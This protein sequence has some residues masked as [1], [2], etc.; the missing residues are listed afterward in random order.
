MFV[1]GCDRHS[2]CACSQTLAPTIAA[3][4]G[5]TIEKDYLTMSDG[6][7]LAVTYFK[8]AAQSES[9]R[10]P[11]VLEM[12][13]YRKDDDFYSR[14]YALER[15]FPARGIAIAR[16]DVRGTGSSE[17]RLPDREYSSQELDDAEELVGVLAGLPWSNGHIGMQGVSWG[18]F[19]SIMTAMRRPAQLKAI[20]AA[21]SSDDLYGSDVHGIDG[22][23]HLDIFMFEIEVENIVPRSPDY[24]VDEGYFKDRFEP[25]PWVFNCLRHQRDGAFW[26]DGRSLQS[27][28][29]AINV[30][31]YAI[32]ALLDGYR[33]T[34][35]HMLD[36]LGV[37]VH[38]EIGPWNHSWPHSGS[39]SP[40]YEWRDTAVRWWKNWLADEPGPA[41][42]GKCLSVFMRG[43]VPPDINL[44]E[45]PG[46]FWIEDWPIQRTRILRLRPEG[47][48]SLAREPG[49]S[50]VH[51]LAYVPSAGVA[52]GNWWGETTGD[53]RPADE[54]AL[55]YD[56][57]VLSE[58]VRVMGIAEAVLD[59]A[60]SAPMADW[61]VRLEDVHPGDAGV[62]LVTGG[63][64]N[65]TQRF[66]RTNPTPIV[67]DETFTLRVPLRFT[68]YTF[69]AGHRIRLVVS[70]AQFPMI[71]PT[72]HAMT[73]SLKVGSEG[74]YVE[75]PTVSQGIPAILPNPVQTDEEP[76]DVEY[77]ASDPLTPFE[78]VADDPNGIT[79][80]ES[81]EASSMR[82]GDKM[83]A[84][85]NTV[86]QSVD[87]L[88]PEQ[89]TLR[90]NGWET[91]SFDS[92][93]SLRVEVEVVIE[94]NATV[95]DTK[96]TR[97]VSENGTLL[98]RH[99]W[100]QAISRDFQ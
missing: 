17:G 57:G 89:A 22:G 44:T 65:G 33:D 29:G 75:I 55:V 1:S 8:P 95:F 86:R 92:G 18:G 76:S 67:P 40:N 13:P 83:F 14:D 35:P 49:K 81:H 58:P 28:W 42:G 15:Y 62:S 54:H 100:R 2:P 66:S 5:V 10:F 56:S 37:P 73:T 47:D 91:I 24:A 68:T 74:S 20:L 64:K 94:S 31:V 23:L 36:N 87:N 72:P 85:K 25:E 90:G 34:V 98:R 6:V 71:W 88:H 96:V 61:I 26:Q 51:K 77:P 50:D 59:V 60:S 4:H 9:E 43:S 63:L 79:E 97:A 12:L 41:F 99:A 93:R 7:R 39:P 48:F 53:M 16:V 70:N 27:D 32:G 45:T 82:V 3:S 80:V 52:V 38:A 30:P 78:I 84:Y 19:N 21:H 11:I 69:E 46:G